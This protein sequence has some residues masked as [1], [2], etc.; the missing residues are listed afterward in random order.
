MFIT[1]Y[2]PWLSG[3]KLNKLKSMLK[4]VQQGEVHREIYQA[5]I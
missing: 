3:A 1:K 5:N 2:K 4:A